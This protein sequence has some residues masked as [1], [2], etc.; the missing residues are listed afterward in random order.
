LEKA[1]CFCSKPHILVQLTNAVGDIGPQ[2]SCGGQR[3]CCPPPSS[4]LPPPAFLRIIRLHGNAGRNLDDCLFGMPTH[5]NKKNWKYF[6][7]KKQKEGV[8]YKQNHI[9][10]NT[11]RS[12]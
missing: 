5:S 3:L 10:V 2:R 9:Q 1:S 6:N 4:L 8:P 7:L 11:K 12:Q